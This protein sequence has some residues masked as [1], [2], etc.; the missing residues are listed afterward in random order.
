MKRENIWKLE[1]YDTVKRWLTQVGSNTGAKSTQRTYLS[2]LNR[3]CKAIRKNPDEIIKERKSHLKSDDENIRRKHEEILLNYFNKL[4]ES[5]SRNSAASHFKTIRSFYKHNY[6]ELKLISPKS[7][8]SHTDRIPSLEDLKKMIDVCESPLQKALILFSAQSGQRAGVIASITY[9]MVKIQLENGDN[10][11]GIH[12]TGD[13]KDR[14]GNL[15]NKNRQEY[16][17]FIGSDAINALK[18]YIEY[19]ENLGHEFKKDSSLFVTTRKYRQFAGTKKEKATYKPI[20]RDALNVY[21]RRSGIKAGLMDDSIIEGADGRKRYPIHHHCMRKFWQTA[22]EQGGI[23]KAW[24]EY[25]M[26]HSLGQLDRAYSKPTI[27]QLKDAYKRAEQYLSIS[28]INIPDLE[29]MKKELLLSVVKEHCKILGF[30][31]KKI[32]IEKEK[33]ISGNITVEDE[34]EILQ[35]EILNATMKNKVNNNKYDHK[36]VTESELTEYLN[37]GWEIVKDLPRGRLVIKSPLPQGVG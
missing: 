29:N 10:P 11:I 34:I 31:P 32:R 5:I 28:R 35:K 36:I 37:Q 19:M 25:M 6:V 18:I 13:L 17:F 23:A 8:T 33:E 1:K 12:V 22:M 14:N 21:V 16:T 2:N 24:Y 26:G 30:D 20:D 15:I 27:N 9:G 7:W 4:T 3:F